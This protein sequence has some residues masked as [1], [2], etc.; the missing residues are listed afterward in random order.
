[1]VFF[2]I[3]LNCNIIV[4][5]FEGGSKYYLEL[6]FRVIIPKRK[7]VKYAADKN[8]LHQRKN[9]SNMPPTE[10]NYTNSENWQK[11]Q[12]HIIERSM[13]IISLR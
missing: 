7:Y 8:K 2:V 13:V 9:M 10:K 12:R 3:L 6:I 1:M 5:C 4:I 11:S